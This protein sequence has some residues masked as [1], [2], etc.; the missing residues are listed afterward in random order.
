MNDVASG[1]VLAVTGIEVGYFADVP[2]LN[3]LDVRVDPGE[4]VAIVGPNGAGS[5]RSSRS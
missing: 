1:A 4:M 2:I 3:G 5:R